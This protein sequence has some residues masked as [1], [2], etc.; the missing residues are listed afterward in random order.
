MTLFEALSTLRLHYY[1][2]YYLYYL[3]VNNEGFSNE[4]LIPGVGSSFPY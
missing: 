1:Y 3:A 4:I 2:H